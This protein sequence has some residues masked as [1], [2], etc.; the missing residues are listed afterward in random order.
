MMGF[1][2]FRR[3]PDG[4]ELSHQTLKEQPFTKMQSSDSNHCALSGPSIS[5]SLYYLLSV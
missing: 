1:F 5:F 4:D 2:P 3:L